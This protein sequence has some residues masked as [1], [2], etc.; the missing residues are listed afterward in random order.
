MGG[1]CTDLPP[2]RAQGRIVRLFA[3]ED[4]PICGGTV[5]AM[6]RHI[7]QI[8]E[9]VGEVVPDDASVDYVFTQDAP[10]RSLDTEACVHPKRSGPIVYS[11]Q[12]PHHHELAHAAHLLMWP[13]NRAFLEEGFAHLFS[14]ESE[15]PAF[16]IYEDPEIDLEIDLDRVF[17]EA[18][19]LTWAQH[20][21]TWIF[22]GQLV[23]THGVAGLR[24]LWRAVPGAP[25]V[26][27]IDAALH[28]SWGGDPLRSSAADVTTAYREVFGTEAA[29]LLTPQSEGE[30]LT[31]CVWILCDEPL[32]WEGDEW[33]LE[34][35][36]PDCEND[37]AA[38]GPLS[39]H[40]NQIARFGTVELEPGTYELSVE[41]GQA[42]G[43]QCAR[44]SFEESGLSRFW[45][46]SPADGPARTITYVVHRTER[47][48]MRTIGW[49]H[50]PGQPL[51]IRR[52]DEG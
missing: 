30:R 49:F 25:S 27:E 8:F 20:H 43:E 23:R 41:D 3:D 6:D 10:C 2:L 4:R 44:C 37:P 19:R 28:P 48:K 18:R 52:I 50:R 15:L 51:T 36:L 32:P 39:V 33:R 40:H 35:P 1:G 13:R 14:E 9:V 7:E 11:P 47:W 29:D 21:G 16:W 24:D 17:A 45:L 12:I 46:W 42:F 22:T 26:A 38:V 31:G 5:E 34:S